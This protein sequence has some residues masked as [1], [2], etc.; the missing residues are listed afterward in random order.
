MQ[1]ADA[2][3][4]DAQLVADRPQRVALLVVARDHAREA[5]GQGRDRIGQHAARLGGAEHLV[6]GQSRSLGGRARLGD[7]LDARRAAQLG[8]REDLV[9]SGERQAGFARDLVVLRVAAE[10][11]LDVLAGPV[12]AA[13][14]RPQAAAQRIGRADLVEHPALDAARRIGREPRLAAVEAAMGVEQA[15]VARAHEVVD[16]HPPGHAPRDLGGER[17]HGRGHPE[18]QV[19]GQGRARGH[20]LRT[21]GGAPKQC[22]CRRIRAAKYA[23]L[24]GFDAHVVR[25]RERA[26][27]MRDYAPSS[28]LRAAC[29]PRSPRRAGRLTGRPP[30]ARLE[31]AGA[32]SRATVA[33]A[34]PTRR[35]RRCAGAWPGASSGRPSG[36][37]PARRA[38]RCCARAGPTA[39]PAPRGPRRW[40]RRP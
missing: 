13:H 28:R 10:A 12:D 3:L 29:Q 33:G 21:L 37:A 18:G 40:R 32:A 39:A 22:R 20:F 7:V 11:G 25:P 35:R 26:P 36:G 14:A 2:R 8:V 30:C 34:P 4:R 19:V 23:E 15:E 5:R 1:L 38:T 27:G 9:V 16:A 24:R 31:P 6:G 17:A